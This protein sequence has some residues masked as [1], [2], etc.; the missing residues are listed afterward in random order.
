MFLFYPNV[1]Y[2]GKSNTWCCNMVCLNFPNVQCSCFP[3]VQCSF[4][5]PNVPFIMYIVL[6]H[7]NILIGVPA[8]TSQVAFGAFAPV[9]SFFLLYFLFHNVN[10]LI[11]KRGK[12]LKSTLYTNTLL[13]TSCRSVEVYCRLQGGGYPKKREHL[14]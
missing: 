7:R 14:R 11:L 2:V 8:S 13:Q 4:L 6:A 12:I 3:N 1:S 10:V 9:F 5:P